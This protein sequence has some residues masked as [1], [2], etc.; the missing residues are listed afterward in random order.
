[1]ALFVSAFVYYGSTGNTLEVDKEKGSFH[2]GLK[3]IC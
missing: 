3:M 2:L 1:M